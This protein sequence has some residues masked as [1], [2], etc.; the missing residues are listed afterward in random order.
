[1]PSL[2]GAPKARGLR[3][4][5]RNDT[6]SILGGQRQ[7]DDILSI[8]LIGAMS[9]FVITLT[10]WCAPG[11]EDEL[12]LDLPEFARLRTLHRQVEAAFGA[13]RARENEPAPDAH[14]DRA[15]LDTPLSRAD[16][17]FT[18]NQRELARQFDAHLGID[19]ERPDPA[20]PEPVSDG[21]CGA[22]RPERDDSS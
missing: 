22:D 8:I 19:G 2:S 21:A 4:G 13:M 10:G 7:V 9:I 18:R 11:D 6:M 15:L 12:E 1:M 5:L 16:A 14:P 17:E 3:E 20:R